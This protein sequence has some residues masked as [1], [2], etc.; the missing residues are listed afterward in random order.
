MTEKM[1]KT[2]IIHLSARIRYIESV[3]G[4]TAENIPECY[5]SVGDQKVWFS[6][7]EMAGM[8]SHAAASLK[9]RLASVV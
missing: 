1:E 3:A 6:P 7:E 8:L 5:V 2:E 4:I 9:V